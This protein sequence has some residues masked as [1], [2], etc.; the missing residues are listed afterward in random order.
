MFPNPAAKVD[1]LAAITDGVYAIVL[2]LL[3]LDLKVPEI[4]GSANN[5]ELAADLID[6]IPNFIAYFISFFVVAI[7]WMNHH[8]L[9]GS[10]K[11][12]DEKTLLFNLS[13]IL[14]VTLTPYTTS[15]IGHYEYDQIAVILFS[16][17]IG[18]A[19]LSLILL[20]QYVAGQTDWHESEGAM[21]W[22]PLK[23]WVIYF[24][25]LLAIVSIG[26]SF[27]SVH[28]A[29]FLLLLLPVR[30]FLLLKRLS[31]SS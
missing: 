8:R 22:V 20:Y 6:Q 7:F 29:L 17:N 14:F 1:R 30:N 26:A 15:L 18:L 21:Q 5:M 23:W 16:A 10:L 24:G 11:Q 2:T 28:L 9:F 31:S 27:V 3:V 12:C 19:S 25:P 13:H 4:P